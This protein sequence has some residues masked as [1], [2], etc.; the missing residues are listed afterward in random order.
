MNAP[1]E[2]LRNIGIIAHID[3][4]KTTLSERILFYTSK[5]HH[6]GEV[7]DGTATMDFM[8]EEQERGITIAA[9][10]S[11]VSWKDWTLNLIDPPGHVDFNY[12]VSRALAACEGAILVV[13]W[14]ER[15]GSLVPANARHVIFTHLEGEESRR[16]VFC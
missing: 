15:A 2:N 5:I 9:A 12:E 14:P 16:I 11:T 6:M 7:H 4:G 1:M 13:G 3:A 10:A 8:P